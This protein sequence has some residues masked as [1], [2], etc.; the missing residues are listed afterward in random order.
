MTQRERQ[1]AETV[2]RACID[3]WREG[4]ESAAMSGLCAEGALEAALSAVQSI[5]LET[6]VDA[7]P[8]HDSNDREPHG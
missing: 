1:L 2:R 3:A 6:L 7:V 5:D 8:G 4:Y